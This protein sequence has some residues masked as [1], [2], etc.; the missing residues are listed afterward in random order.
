MT[1]YYDDGTCQCGCGGVVRSGRSYVSGHNFRGQVKTEA[2]RRA[3][4]DGQR[5]AWQRK[6]QRLPVGTTRHDAAGYVLVKIVA[7]KG[8]WAKQHVLVMEAEIRR[9]LFPGEVVHHINGLHDDN[10]AENLHLFIAHQGHAQA[11][12]SY[13]RLLAG[14]IADGIVR[15]NR[16]TGEY[17]RC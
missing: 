11:H 7:G 17:E 5:S 2:H 13:E 10:R 16:K 4:S 14:L 3:I 9:R 8:R 15:F 1:P 12:N 6:R